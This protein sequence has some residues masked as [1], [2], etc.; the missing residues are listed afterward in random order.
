MKGKK[1]R[2]LISMDEETISLLAQQAERNYR[3]RAQ[4]C[5]KILFEAAR[6]CSGSGT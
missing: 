2:I 1:R 4:E 5:C 3:S 6:T